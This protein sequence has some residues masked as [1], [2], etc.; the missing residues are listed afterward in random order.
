MEERLEMKTGVKKKFKLESTIVGPLIALLLVSIIVAL[1]TER[2]L[3]PINLK[4]IF[5]QV[6]TVAL[7]AI[8]STFVILTG[9]IDLSP[10]SMVALLTML[11]SMSIKFIGVPV[12]LAVIMVIV[13]GAVL[14]SVNGILSTY[15]RIPAFIATLATMSIFRGVA[16]MFNNGS[17]VFS[18][19]PA[20]EALFY[21]TVM[22]IPV[23][24]IYVIVFF[25]GAFV[26]MKYTKLGREIYA[27]G[28]NMSASKLSGIN[29]NKVRLLT[30]MFAGSMAA[31]AS[32]LMTARLNSGSANYGAGMEMSAIAATVVG[33]TSLTGGHG[34]VV[35]TLLGA[36]TIVV[37]QNALNLHAVPTSLQNIIIGIIIVLAV[38]ID[39]WRDE[40]Q[41]VYTKMKSKKA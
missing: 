41:H 29:V 7:M 26:F 31:V 9:G 18:V 6:S 35:S 14:G 2:F 30:F 32:V 36:L 39:M 38:A 1:T 33:G 37:V 4:N 5:L 10:G 16:F 27:V 22:G 13:L 15:L 23:T 40:L 17:P 21:G 11:L 25:A 8:G 3:D 12:W 19:S 20:L 24:L 34:N 28:G